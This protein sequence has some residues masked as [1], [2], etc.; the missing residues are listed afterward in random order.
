MKPT[1]FWDFSLAYYG[2]PQVAVTCLEL[3][4]IYGVNVNLLLWSLWLESEHLLLTEERLKAAINV[5]ST[6]EQSYVWPLRQLRRSMKRDFAVSPGQVAEVREQIKQAEFLAEKQEQQ[7]LQDLVSS[8]KPLSEPLQKNQN[9]GVYLLYLDL[10][11][12]VIERATS[13]CGL[14]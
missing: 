12:A 13:Q 7:W 6:W 1:G 4:D 14:P 9:L 5:V 10:P 8:W 3:Q 11:L 2:N